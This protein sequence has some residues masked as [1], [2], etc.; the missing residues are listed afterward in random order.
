MRAA[1][2]SALSVLI[3]RLNFRIP[4]TCP[5]FIFTC[6]R[7]PGDHLK[8]SAFNS[9]TSA[10]S[11]STSEFRSSNESAVATAASWPADPPV[12]VSIA[13]GVSSPHHSAAQGGHD[14][15]RWMY[16]LRG[17][18]SRHPLCFSAKLA[19]ASVGTFTRFKRF[20]V[21]QCLHLTYHTFWSGLRILPARSACVAVSKRAI[22]PRR[23]ARGPMLQNVTPKKLFEPKLDYDVIN[24]KLIKEY[25]CH[26][27]TA[28]LH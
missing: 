6:Q 2:T 16:F 25:D 28:A 5:L 21:L 10:F 26:T 22:P 3:S 14:Q 4:A 13:V 24:A 8:T 20:S 17:F 7:T 11:C 18:D 23:R 27:T 1:M 19:S 15:L 9:W 12:S